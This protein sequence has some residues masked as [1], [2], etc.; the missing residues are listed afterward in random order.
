M[1]AKTRSL[2]EQLLQDVRFGVRILYR[3]PVFT[4]V[5]V[6]T[7]ALGVGLNTAI[8]SV[9]N[10]VLIRPVPYPHAE[11][12][13]WLT[14]YNSV[15]KAEVVPGVDFLDWQAQAKSFAEL[16]AY[17]YFQPTIATAEAIEPHRIAQVTADFW[18]L[19]DARPALGH[20]FTG[21]DRDGLV[22][23]DELFRHQFRGDPSVIGRIVTLGEHSVTILGVLPPTFHFALPQSLF[24]IEPLSP[25]AKE[26]EGYILNPIAPGM[27]THGGPMTIQLVVARLRPGVSKSG[28]NAEL[29]AIQARMA[30]VNLS[31]SNSFSVPRVM[32]LQEKLVGTARPA[33]LILLGAVGFVLLIACANI[34][35][36]LLARATARRKEIAIRMAIGAGRARILRQFM[37]ENLVLGLLGGFS[38]V[39]LARL[40]V[41][42]LVGLA[43][44]AVPRLRE[45]SVDWRVM[46]FALCLTL[47]AVVL[48]GLS[49]VLSLWHS[50]TFDDLRLGG[51]TSSAPP[52]NLT[53]R[54]LLVGA[55][56]AL[57]IVLLTGA[58]LLI[59]SFSRMNVHSPGLDPDRTI[60]LQV[61][62]T[63]PR[64]SAIPQQRF[65]F[66]QLLSRIEGVPG[67]LAACVIS[68]V[69]RGPIHQ[70]GK[71]VTL[72]RENP[73]A[74]YSITSAMFARVLGVRLVKGRL[75]NDHELDTSVV[76]NE[77]F[78]RLVFGNIE[79][80]GRRI[81][82]PALAPEPEETPARVVGVTSD[83]KYRRLDAAPQPE[84][85]L[86]YLQALNLQG[87]SL[88]VRTS[89]DTLR[90]EPA[91]RTAAAE[92]DRTQ[93]LGQ[94][95]TLE[96][97]LT[98]S[99][100]PQRFNLVL[101][102]AFAA[103]ALFL[104]LVGIYGV[105][106]YFVS[107][108]TQEI[109]IRAA[110]GAPG[111]AIVRMVVRQGMTVV[112]GGVVIGL[113]AALGLTRLMASLL[114]E[115]KPTDPLTF[116]AVNLLFALAALFASWIPARR[117]ARVDPLV[118]LRSE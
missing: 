2:W 8:F 29:K 108:R 57:A 16:V 4:S 77:S 13:V 106:A 55:E 61:R 27:E 66:Q 113:S 90:I 103:S 105:N 37:G 95:R 94:I 78:A 88:M 18:K 5:V 3:K 17:S 83:L 93:P 110:L 104:A 111:G 72:S 15:L 98:E 89:V 26:I 39:L 64:Y 67:V 44:E 45:V 28:A 11:R 69:A 40:A 92:I 74:T 41:S 24:G 85:F 79:P 34:A 30:R 25:G 70:E 60:V 117:A 112:L 58:G 51:R 46:L 76:I 12:L 23:S 43:P 116:V 20:L 114:F 38:G 91:I 32:G 49:P 59:R 1:L 21:K 118:A 81:M 14:E 22:L 86:P 31:A 96:Q 48:F 107:Q 56:V 53:V 71:I 115:V 50:P 73:M 33:L 65:Y 54:R 47:L 75:L 82:V 99:V 6:L 52:S 35:S 62:F 100:V 97:F 42:V 84:A 109:G 9:V 80:I 36:L 102:A 10:T 19:T 7:L 63:Q 101:L 87:A 68:T